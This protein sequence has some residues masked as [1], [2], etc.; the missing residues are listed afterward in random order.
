MAEGRSSPAEAP[1]EPYIEVT[2]QEASEEPDVR[3]TQQEAPEEPD[4]RVTH[5][6]AP[7]EPNVEDEAYDQLK[8]TYRL[9]LMLIKH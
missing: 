7:E 3:V 9:L 4:V 6:E 2:Q 8:A 5:Q 1:E